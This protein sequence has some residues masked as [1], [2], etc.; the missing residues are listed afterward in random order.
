MK[1]HSIEDTLKILIGHLPR[2]VN[3]KIFRRDLHILNSIN[4]QLTTNTALTDRQLQFI[5]SKFIKYKDGLILNEV[6]V[7]NTIKAKQ[8]KLPL[9]TI[10]RIN[11]ISI[12]NNRLNILHDNSSL[13]RSQWSTIDNLSSVINVSPTE[14]SAALTEHNIW[15]IVSE[16]LPL[17]FEIDYEVMDLYDQITEIINNEHQYRPELVINDGKFQ[18]NNISNK[19]QTA[20]D[21]SLSSTTHNILQ[22]VYRLKD[23]G[24]HANDEVKSLLY[25]CNVDEFSKEIAINKNSRFRINSE[26]FEFS[27][28]ATIITQLDAYPLLIVVNENRANITQHVAEIVNSFLTTLSN[29]EITVFFRINKT[30]KANEEFSN[31]VKHN[32]LNNN[33]TSNTKVVIISRPRLP[34]VLLTLDW[35][36][37][38]AVVATQHDYGKVSC[39]TDE[40]P[41]IIYHNNSIL[42]KNDKYKGSI[43]IVNLQTNNS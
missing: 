26:N 33:I 25:N 7:D 9:R 38:A 23:Y 39:Y 13:F 2:K 41:L 31:Y 17:N 18:I 6:D 14:K 10:N 15:K 1:I 5:I 37:M 4:Y 27:K 16:L 11:K 43:N 28:I 21:N 35:K 22:Y 40:L 12:K 19:C 34:K 32:K 42:L 8:L 3:I 24:I 30:P 36:P 29:T 20:I